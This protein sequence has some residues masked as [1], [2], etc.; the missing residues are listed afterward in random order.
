MKKSIFSFC[1]ALVLLF[2]FTVTPM[3]GDNAISPLCDMED[4]Y[5]ECT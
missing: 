4:D 3:V 5:I 1:L 2:A